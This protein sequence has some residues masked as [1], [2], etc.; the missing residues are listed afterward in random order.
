MRPGWNCPTHWPWALIAKTWSVAIP[1]L[2]PLGR[3]APSVARPTHLT[4][5][6][7]SKSLQSIHGAGWTIRFAEI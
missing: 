2:R 5:F 3:T 1:I 4:I 7:P 6:R